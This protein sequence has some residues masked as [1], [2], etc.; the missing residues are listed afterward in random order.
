MKA[1][2]KI[3]IGL[4]SLLATVACADNDRPVAITSL[5]QPAQQFVAQHFGDRTVALAKEDTDILKKSYDV[6]FTDGCSVE[7]DGRV[8]WKE[9]DCK[10]SE[11]P[12]AV[13]PVPIQ[14]YVKTNYPD[15]RILK[16]ERDR[17]EYEVKL[18]NR[19]ELTFD[20]WFALVDID[21]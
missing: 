3:L 2:Q 19:V 17:R 9:V 20:R 14:E 12:A 5:P 1:S 13:V 18:S 7:F 10:F 21:Y 4:F 8:D 6:I 15:V 11:V 16:I